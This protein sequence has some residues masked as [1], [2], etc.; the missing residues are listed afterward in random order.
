MFAICSICNL[1]LTQARNQDPACPEAPDALLSR[2]DAALYRAKR[3]GRDR[4]E[5]DLRIVGA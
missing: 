3:A 4:A 1:K 2:A 5:F